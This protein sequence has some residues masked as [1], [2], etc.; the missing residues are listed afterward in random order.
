VGTFLTDL[1]GLDCSNDTFI[2]RKDTVRRLL[3]AMG[4]LI[5]VFITFGLVTSLR[6]PIERT[7]GQS[8]RELESAM[9]W[10]SD[11]AIACS[12]DMVAGAALEGASV[13]CTTSEGV[14]VALFAFADVETRDRWAAV[15]G[16]GLLGGPLVVPATT[17]WLFATYSEAD[18]AAVRNDLREAG[19]VVEPQQT[20]EGVITLPIP[21]T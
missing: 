9:D 20:C 4:A 5:A 16:C 8:G 7:F 19:I 17:P 10:L 6:D 1:Q 3:I 15:E 13:A 18:V 12:R 2:M 11:R 21:T 14:N